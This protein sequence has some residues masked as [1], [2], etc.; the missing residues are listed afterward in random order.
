MCIW[1]IKGILPGFGLRP[2]GTLDQAQALALKTCAAR[3]KFTRGFLAN[4][5]ELLAQ[6]FID[7]CRNLVRTGWCWAGIQATLVPTV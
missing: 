4:S 3:S 5:H 7:L 2:L 1:L 6:V